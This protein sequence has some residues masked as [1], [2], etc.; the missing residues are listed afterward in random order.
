MTFFAAKRF[1][2]RFEKSMKQLEAHLQD[3]TMAYHG[4]PHATIHNCLSNDRI[5]SFLLQRSSIKHGWIFFDHVNVHPQAMSLINDSPQQ[6]SQKAIPHL[7]RFVP[8]EVMLFVLDMRLQL[9]ERIEGV[10]GG[11]DASMV[12]QAHDTDVDFLQCLF[13]LTK[14]TI[15]SAKMNK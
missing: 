15:Q 5:R 14:A 1:L 12:D 8:R 11:A 7:L 2:C 3:C 10:D 6:M 4:S 9:G 13:P